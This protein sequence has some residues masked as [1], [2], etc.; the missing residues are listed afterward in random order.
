MQSRQF[1]NGSQNP[2]DTE[3]DGCRQGCEPDA[4]KTNSPCVLFQI[5]DDLDIPLQDG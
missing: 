1:E 5:S 2:E 4:R 3:K